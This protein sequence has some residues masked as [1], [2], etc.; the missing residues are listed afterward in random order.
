MTVVACTVALS[1]YA[2]DQGVAGFLALCRWYAAHATDH[3]V[4][5]G[6]RW[7]RITAPREHVSAAT[8]RTD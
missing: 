8:T 1:V 4:M 6:V 3:A 7:L 2:Q 5:P